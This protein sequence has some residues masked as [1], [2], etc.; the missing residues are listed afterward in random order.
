MNQRR[1]SLKRVVSLSHAGWTKL[2]FVLLALA[3]TLSVQISY[4]IGPTLPLDFE[5][6]LEQRDAWR[7]VL[8]ID[9]RQ[10]RLERVERQ[11][12]VN[13][14]KL[15]AEPIDPYV[16]K[17]SDERTENSSAVLLSLKFKGIES[18]PSGVYAQKIFAEGRW[19]KEGSNKPLYVQRWFY[20]MVREGYVRRI[21]LEQYSGLTDQVEVTFDSRGRQTLIHRGIELK[22]A[23]PLPQTKATFAVPVGAFGGAVPERPPRDIKRVAQEIDRSEVNEK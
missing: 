8:R 19:L 17:P 13:G 11:L 15:R 16:E 2:L 18:L 10:I 20:F 22:A 23:V 3:L 21:D 14:K 6:E 1:W 9:P 4:A 7:V 12:Y 5:D